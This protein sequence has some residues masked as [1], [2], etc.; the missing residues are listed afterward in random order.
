MTLHS[1]PSPTNVGTAVHIM[2]ATFQGERYLQAQL[3][4]IAQQTH[5]NWTL[6]ISDDGSK[7]QTIEICKNFAQI[8]SGR[9]HILK[10]PERG[11][12]ANFFNLI[13]ETPLTQEG[14]FF[15]FS[16]QDD[17]WHP[18]K[19]SQ[20]LLA[21][22]SLHTAPCQPL[23]YCGR[24]RVVDEHLKPLGMSPQ[25]AKP[26]GFGN[27]LVQNVVNG[28]TMVFNAPLL[29]LLRQVKPEHAV[30]HDWTAYLAAT[31]CGGKIWFDP[32]PCL[33]YRQ[34]ALNVVGSQG[35]L[36]D[37]LKRMAMVFQGQYRQWGD[38]TE[39]IV[40]DLT[41]FLSEQARSQAQAFKKMRN[42][43]WPWSRLIAGWKSGIWRQTISGQLSFF[44]ALA[45][46][47]L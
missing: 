37:K 35:R 34:H 38:Q 7:D 40:E 46:K 28:N 10:G 33:D 29:R 17:V 12:T 3:D 47:K 41:P 11:A 2:M 19:L 18:R 25:P 30:L 8:H 14:G 23:L 5:T 13:A 31:G 24:T 16:D 39:A 4:S 22:E 43:A 26:L 32:E 45:C 9:V 1:I 21:I 6:T 44:M 27:A 36:R 15:A 42:G 20:A